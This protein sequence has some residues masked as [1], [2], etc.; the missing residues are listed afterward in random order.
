MDKKKLKEAEWKDIAG[1]L[2]PEQLE[3]LTESLKQL[4]NGQWKP[5]EEVMRLARTWLKK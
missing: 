4:D 5:N 2:A 3:R 1:K